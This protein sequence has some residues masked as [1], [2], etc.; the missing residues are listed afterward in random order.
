MTVPAIAQRLFDDA[1]LFPPGNA[2][3]PDAV[4][5]HV[6]LNTAWYAE[7][8]GRF[9][10]PAGRLAELDAEL[11]R[12]GSRLAVAV[13]VP[14]GPD[15]LS[16]AVRAARELP[17]IDL[18]AVELPVSVQ[19]LDQA[20][21]RLRPVIED[22]LQVFAELP[23]AELTPAVATRLAAAGVL[24][25]LRTGGTSQD[26]FPS[27]DALAAAVT[28]TVAAGL[29]FKCTAGLHHAV[30]H[31]DPSTGLA[32]YGFLNVL[33][34]VRAAQTGADPREPLH[35]GDQR[36]LADQVSALTPDQVAELRAQLRSIG[37]CSVTEPLEDLQ[38]LGLVGTR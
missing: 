4:A 9:I 22:G 38:L 24:A 23:A 5:E 8:V 3:M 19:S 2:A 20:V 13:T 17:G 33:L 25:K 30:A 18:V 36:S 7:L 15:G 34:A 28:S 10:C 27:R 29:A 16:D 1:A 21:E 14:A 12:T 6:A 31:T 11:G 32:H 35:N 37:S 26:A